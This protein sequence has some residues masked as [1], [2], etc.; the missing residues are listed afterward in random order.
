MTPGS[1][2]K[3]PWRREWLPTPVFLDFMGGSAGKESACHAGDL[4]SIPRSEIFPG[5]GNGNPL[6]YSFFFFLICEESFY[7][8][9]QSFLFIVLSWVLT[10][11]KIIFQESRV[12]IYSIVALKLN[13]ELHAYEANWHIRIDIMTF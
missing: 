3:I 12:R 6:Q 2:R 13:T 5:D 9:N 10:F 11:N 8:V 1:V 7:F 4:G